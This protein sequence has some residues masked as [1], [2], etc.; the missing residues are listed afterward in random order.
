M[1][2]E[3]MDLGGTNIEEP[4]SAMSGS[5]ELSVLA[6]SGLLLLCRSQ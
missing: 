4:S 1:G 2:M 5:L 3:R 6:L